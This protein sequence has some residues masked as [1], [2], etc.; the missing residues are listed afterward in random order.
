MNSEI[1]LTLLGGFGIGTIVT[2]IIQHILKRKSEKEDQHFQERKEVFVGILQSIENLQ[3]EYSKENSSKLGYWI[4]RANL[5]A[6]NELN[7]EFINRPII[8]LTFI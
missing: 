8:I 6:G 5:V 7:D 4:A 1:F 2:T 3:N